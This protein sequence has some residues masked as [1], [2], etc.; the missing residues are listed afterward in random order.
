MTIRRIYVTDPLP[1]TP[2]EHLDL[3]GEEH[4]YVSTVLRLGPGDRV[5]LFDRDGRRC[6]AVI[7]S[8]ERRRTVLRIERWE[9]AVERADSPV[10]VVLF[11]A[12]LKGK[13][14]EVVLQKATE[15]GVGRVVPL[16]TER[17]VPEP[18]ASKV[19]GRVERWQRICGEAARQ[20]GRRTVPVVEVPHALADAVAIAR[21]GVRF[22]LWEGERELGLREA[23]TAAAS[24]E[25]PGPVTLLVGPEGGLTRGEIDL[26][27]TAGF[28]TV[29]LGARIL[30][31]ETAPLAALVAVQLLLGDLGAAPSPDDAP[32]G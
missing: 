7:E 1:A 17:T 14:F 2:C 22:A 15:L 30:R 8:V 29:S 24:Q 10:D 4:S 5:Q 11:L 18:P 3:C 9:A 28:R 31:A 20:C 6:D 21:L 27:V 13:S 32:T 26:A 16:I 23:L 12:L 19:D 25:S